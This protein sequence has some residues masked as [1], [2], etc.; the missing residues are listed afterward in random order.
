MNDQTDNIRTSFLVEAPC[1]PRIRIGNRFSEID[2]L[3][4]QSSMSVLH[5]V[6]AIQSVLLG[7]PPISLRQYS[8]RKELVQD[9][10]GNVKG[11]LRSLHNGAQ[12]Q[13]FR[14]QTSVQTSHRI[15]TM[16]Y[17]NG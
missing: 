6:P 12:I 3:T 13:H 8:K 7:D 11:I 10:L 5:C 4:L 16:D 9:L 17:P 1:I 14:L 2:I 15:H